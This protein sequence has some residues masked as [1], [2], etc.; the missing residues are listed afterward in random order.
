[1]IFVTK[2]PAY[3]T[4]NK[5]NGRTC[6]WRTRSRRFGIVD[7]KSGSP[8]PIGAGEDGNKPTPVG[9][10]SSRAWKCLRSET[11]PW[12]WPWL[13]LR[14]ARA[15]KGEG[16]GVA[17]QQQSDRALA[18]A[19]CVADVG[20]GQTAP[21]VTSIASGCSM[22]DPRSEM[23]RCYNFEQI[24]WRHGERRMPT[25]RT[26]RK[27]TDHGARSVGWLQAFPYY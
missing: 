21:Y 27:A 25:D 10:S 17:E 24:T 3:T 11:T 5:N 15:I 8:E 18:T 22:I 6:P 16:Q 20:E 9:L 4:S 13:C 19:S 1:M 23:L 7:H 2:N 12:P 26:A 14:C